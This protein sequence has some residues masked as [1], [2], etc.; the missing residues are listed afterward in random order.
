MD[1]VEKR[2][3][4]AEAAE[5]RGLEGENKRPKDQGAKKKNFFCTILFLDL[6][7]RG[8]DPLTSSKL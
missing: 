4:Q 8:Q 7:A 2:R 5:K 1:P 3:L 6:V